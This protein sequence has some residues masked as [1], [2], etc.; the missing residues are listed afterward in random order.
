[1]NSKLQVVTY[2]PYSEA[3]NPF[4]MIPAMWR[5]LA[6]SREL[7]F[8]LTV[9]DISAKYRE[10]VLGLLWAFI[11]PILAGIV[12]IF[13]HSRKIVDFGD[14]GM[15]YPVFA[16]IGTALW[17]L[18]VESINAPLRV[19]N[20]A[21]P[22]LAKINFPREA[23]ILSAFYQSLFTF[24]IKGILLGAI[25]VYFGVDLTYKSILFIVPAM[26]LIWLGL[27]IGLLLTPLGMLYRD[28]SS[29]VMIFTQFLF[30]LTPVVYAVPTT[31]PY[32]LLAV[33][34]PVSP[35]LNAARDLLVL[36]TVDNITVL[37]V[38][39]ILL[40]V[41]LFLGWFIYRLAMPVLIE[42]ISA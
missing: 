29:S 12:F 35:Y 7:A 30:F 25:I 34:N 38:T 42:R 31:Y 1:M 4:K 19:V 15:P 22:M 32:S 33:L 21:K 11:P 41:F 2:T 3:S 6:A 23:L 37:V 20:A 5:D 17:Q 27:V 40:T 36:G 28:V 8:R 16:F 14:V 26:L 39:T 9:R 18:F 13:L 10:S 24:F